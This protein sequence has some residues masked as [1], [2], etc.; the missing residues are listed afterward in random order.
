MQSISRLLLIADRPLNSP[1]AGHLNPVNTQ[2]SR[3]SLPLSS[4]HSPQHPHTPNKACCL[5]N[6]SCWPW[7]LP[8][9]WPSSP[10]PKVANLNTRASC[11]SSSTMTTAGSSPSAPARL[12]LGP[13]WTRWQTLIRLPAQLTDTDTDMATVRVASPPERSSRSTTSH[14]SRASKKKRP[15]MTAKAAPPRSRDAPPKSAKR[16]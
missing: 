9:S 12:V 3:H 5:S 4:A 10:S 13:P 16:P 11:R 2:P 6:P 1:T 8:S 15:R 7:P 14:R